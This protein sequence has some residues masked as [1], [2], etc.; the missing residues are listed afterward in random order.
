MRKM[1]I[2]FVTLCLL[3]V[4]VAGIIHVF[5][6]TGDVATLMP[7]VARIDT[8]MLHPGMNCKVGI[9]STESSAAGACRGYSGIV[10]EVN[11]EELI[12]ERA[13]YQEISD[14]ETRHEVGTVHVPI[15]EIAYFQHWGLPTTDDG[16]GYQR[17]G[18]VFR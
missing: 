10:V 12:L 1:T 2:G 15:A 16:D 5:R 6:K 8:S 17:I 11:E 13:V 7:T 18:V 3:S 14:S 9:V 4:S